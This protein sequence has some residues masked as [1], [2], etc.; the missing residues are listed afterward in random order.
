MDCWLLQAWSHWNEGTVTELIDA[1]LSERYCMEE[2]IRCI[3]IGL[4]CVQEKV[5]DRPTMSSVVLMLNKDSVTL[6][7][8]LPPVFSNSNRGEESED[9]TGEYD[10]TTDE[11][12]LSE[13]KLLCLPVN[14]ESHIELDDL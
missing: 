3:H 2:V 4:L 1:T 12:K 14:E 6:P 9:H 7:R 5:T 10:S 11:L 8:P 13:H